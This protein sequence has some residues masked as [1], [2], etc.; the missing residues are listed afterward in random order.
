[1]KRLAFLLALLWA[2]ML[3]VSCGPANSLNQADSTQLP[4]LSDGGHASTGAEIA[5]FTTEE[6][7]ESL[8]IKETW[9]AISRFTGETGIT[10]G[11]YQTEDDYDALRATLELAVKG[12][13]RLVVACGDALAA[14]VGR[15][16]AQHPELE[17]LLL[18]VTAEAEFMPNTLAVRFASEQAGWLAG[19]AAVYERPDAL[20]VY[21]PV[22]ME[23]HRYAVGFI[24]GAETAA[25]E[26]QLAPAALPLAI[27]QGRQQPQEESAS[28][29]ASASSR[30][31]A[32]QLEMLFA[33]RE[34]ILF[35]N[36]PAAQSQA[37]SDVR[38]AGGRVI[39]L[40]AEVSFGSTHLATVQKVPRAYVYNL[41]SEWNNGSF[42][43]MMQRRCGVAEGGLA[44][45]MEEA[46][47]QFFT[48]AQYEASLQQFAG[49]AL[50]EE[51]D[52]LCRPGE[53]GQ[54]PGLTELL[55]YQYLYPVPAQP[56]QTS[57]SLPVS[58]DGEDSGSETG[59][60]PGGT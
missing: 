44:L 31:A 45:P 8:F 38:K 54:L 23:S 51:L 42:D 27:L 41:L 15:V 40:D 11:A 28:Q 37:A 21:E 25:A 36:D 48:T 9:N 4:I 12:G 13:A 53:D 33:G 24:R 50:S 29:E 17:Y 52:Q 43:E 60:E 6:Q 32:R 57:Q 58:A 7:R 18:D 46:S 19:Y 1:M 16:Q 5:L 34:G 22:D 26:R 49:G 47:F 10:S 30:Q 14:L 2:G 55:L 3:L 59:S 56:L 35:A 39:G 20:A